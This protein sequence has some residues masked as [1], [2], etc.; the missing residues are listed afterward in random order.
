MGEPRNGPLASG[1]KHLACQPAPDCDQDDL[2][3]ILATAAA[4]H[5]AVVLRDRCSYFNSYLKIS[6]GR[7]P[8]IILNAVFGERCRGALGLRGLISHCAMFTI[9]KPAALFAALQSL[10]SRPY[11]RSNDPD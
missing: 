11:S 5:R 1:C 7:H 3:G 8:S 2:I 6:A 10:T 4:A 9:E